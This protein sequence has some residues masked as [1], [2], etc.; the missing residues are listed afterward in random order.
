M[1]LREH[2]FLQSEIATLEGLLADLSDERV[3]ERLGFEHRLEEARERLRQALNQ[4]QARSLPITFRG[5]PVEGSKSIDATFASEAL[6]AF[7]AATDTV[8]A[9]LATEDLKGSGR[10]PGSR[11]RTLRIVDTAVGS[12][13]FELELPPLETPDPHGQQLMLG[14]PEPSDPYAEAITTTFELIRRAAS[15]D[16]GTIS[17]LVADIHPRAAAKVRGFAKVLADHQA[18]FAAEF[19]GQHVRLSHTQEV[20]HILDALDEASISELEQT[21]TATVLGILPNGRQFEARLESGE[22]IKGKVDRSLSDLAE[23]KVSVENQTKPLRFSIVT[24]RSNRRYVLLGYPGDDGDP[25][26]P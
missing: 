9:S 16:E 10:L 21:L 13:G 5:D 8:A 25:P 11:Q 6:K 12:F 14:L 19:E 20:Q 26:S 22:L 7:V 23:F 15:S 2:Q 3:I 17:D 24:V 4:P 18:L 1:S